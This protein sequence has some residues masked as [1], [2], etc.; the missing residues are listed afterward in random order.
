MKIGRRI[1]EYCDS[2]VITHREFADLA[3]VSEATV[4]LLTQTEKLPDVD[5]IKRI[6]FAFHCSASDLLA[7][8]FR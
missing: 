6:A 7:E 1:K 3:G 5:D 2:H 4:S 8:H